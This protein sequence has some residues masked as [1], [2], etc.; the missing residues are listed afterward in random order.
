MRLNFNYKECSILTISDLT[1][2]RKT[3]ELEK[4]NLL[5]NL[6]TANVSHELA[7]PL[8]CISS[9]AKLLIDILKDTPHQRFA[10]MIANAASLMRFQVMD[11]LDRSLIEKN[12]F[13]PNLT[14][15]NLDK[16]INDVIE[17]MN[18]QAQ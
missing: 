4:Q 5:I 3:C 1:K 6:L 2:S 18:G 7:T 11:L 15:T 12:L 14:A 16:T 13:A 10:S 8:N 17:I 9:F